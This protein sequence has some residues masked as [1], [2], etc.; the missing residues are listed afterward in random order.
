M[1]IYYLQE[2]FKKRKGR[3]YNMGQ[4]SQIY[5][6]YNKKRS[7]VARHLQWN[8]GYYMIN[9]TYQLLDFLKKNTEENEYSEFKSR[10]YDDK[11]KSLLSYFG[12]TTD[13]DI[14]K[15]L[16]E[17]N[18]T[19]GSI[20]RSI[21]LVKEEKEFGEYKESA[22]FKM[23]PQGQDNNNGILVIDLQEDEKN[24]V[25]VKYGLALGYE[26]NGNLDKMVGASEY[27]KASGSMEYLKENEKEYYDII[28]KDMEKQIKYIEENFELL[29]D[30]EFKEIFDTEYEFAWCLGDDK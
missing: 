22:T 12:K 13:K 9:R 23:I 30:E 2:D 1:L 27:L 16:I 11:T 3:V 4:R 7:L 20:V 10:N 15:S 18:L 6:R 28:S 17:M 25:K 14:L 21:D 5:I 24:N 26:E 8:Y 19:I 29:T